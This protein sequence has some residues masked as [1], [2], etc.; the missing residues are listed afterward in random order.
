MAKATTETTTA[1]ARGKQL[2][3]TVS[4]DVYDAFQD[5]H[6]EAK[7]ETVDIVRDA[8]HGYGIEKGFLTIDAE[9]NVVPV[10]KA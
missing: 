9:G 8:L 1:S 2:Q 5:Y 4:G 6:W 3:A 7:K 10:N